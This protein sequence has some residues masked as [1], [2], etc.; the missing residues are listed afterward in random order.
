MVHLERIIILSATL[1]ACATTRWTPGVRETGAGY[2]AV[3]CQPINNDRAAAIEHARKDAQWMLYES[4]H[5]RSHHE[6]SPQECDGEV[7]V[8]VYNG[9]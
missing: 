6:L 1:I 4:Y 5:I 2:S 9:R 7:C 3:A 8:K